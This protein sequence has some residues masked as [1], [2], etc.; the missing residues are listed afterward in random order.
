MTIV[1]TEALFPLVLLV[2]HSIGLYFL[3]G[4]ALFHASCAFV[5]GLNSFFWAFVATY[6]AIYF[7]RMN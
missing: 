7:L 2:P 5:M 1:V 6:P 4:G 3:V